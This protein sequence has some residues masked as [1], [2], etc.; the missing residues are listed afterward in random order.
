MNKL[1]SVLALMVIILPISVNLLFNGP[2]NI[3]AACTRFFE[4]LFE[5]VVRFGTG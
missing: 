2:N 3:L 4:K 1:I 5:Q